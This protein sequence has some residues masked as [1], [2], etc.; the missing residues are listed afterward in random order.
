MGGLVLDVVQSW[1]LLLQAQSS[2][3]NSVGG[4]RS[5]FPMNNEYPAPE[6]ELILVL[7]RTCKRLVICHV[8]WGLVIF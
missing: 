7:G 2:K 3:I 5:W 6:S 8:Y 1:A 4:N